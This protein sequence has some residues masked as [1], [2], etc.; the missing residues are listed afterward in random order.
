MSASCIRPLF[1]S[2]SFFIREY[3]SACPAKTI[4]SF[5]SI[6]PT[7]LIA[8]VLNQYGIK[9]AL[10][11]LGSDE[12]FGGYSYFKYRNLQIL[13]GANGTQ[14]GLKYLSQFLDQS[15][16]LHKLFDAI[17][18]KSSDRT[19]TKLIQHFSDRELNRIFCFNAA[20]LDSTA[21]YLHKSYCDGVYFQDAFEAFSFMSLKNYIGNHFMDRND[22]FLMSKSVE[23]RFPFLDHHLIESSFTIP[24]K[25]KI[26]W[27]ANKQ[28]VK[29]VAKQ[30]VA[31]LKPN[32]RKIGFGMP[33]SHWM[34]NELQEYVFDSLVRLAERPYINEDEIK[35]LKYLYL[36][37][38]ISY[39]KIWH[40]VSLEQWNQC[41]IDR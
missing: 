19:Y 22:S 5:L 17:T 18:Q 27:Q 34:K 28:L 25:Y 1:R 2:L 20:D 35:R 10:S 9:V 11:G 6:S 13:G 33:L 8:E 16:N 12:I 32:A 40:L 7:L 4:V 36:K 39:S 24:T 26:Q 14:Q 37:G 3:L 38:K 15:G 41:Y 23:G 30:Y 21:I 31:G 29:K